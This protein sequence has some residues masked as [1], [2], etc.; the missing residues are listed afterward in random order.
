MFV[1]MHIDSAILVDDR[2][3]SRNIKLLYSSFV[4]MFIMIFRKI[5]NFIFRQYRY[6]SR[7]IRLI[8]L[9]FFMELMILLVALV[10][11]YFVKIVRD[12]S[13]NIKLIYS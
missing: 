2:D 9:C 11:L 8:Y 5:R 6:A 4:I 12:T 13:R 7:N 10:A 3:D 1:N